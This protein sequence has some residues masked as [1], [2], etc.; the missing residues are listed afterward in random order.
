VRQPDRTDGTDHEPIWVAM[1]GSLIRGPAGEPRHFCIELFDLTERRRVAQA[2]RERAVAQAADRAK[3]ELLALVSHDVRTPLHAV[4]GFAQ[5]LRSMQLPPERQLAA[6]DHILGAGRHLLQLMNDLLD[7]TGAETGQLQLVLEPVQA[8]EVV[9]EAMEIVAGL[10]DE[11]SI[12]LRSRPAAGALAV[13]ADRHR[14]RQVLLNLLGNAIKF[15]PVGG[16]V[17]VVMGPGKILVVDNGDGIPPDQ[18]PFLFTPFHRGAAGS[19]SGVEGSGLGL[20]LSQRLMRAM[21]GDLTLVTSS[22]KGT[23]FRLTLPT[24]SPAAI[25]RELRSP[26]SMR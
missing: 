2:R 14:L 20:A 23:T 7:L 26:A 16:A 10:A 12:T 17:D 4:I 9:A 25:S 19:T 15:T 22:N 18:L 8:R 11:R 6:I 1:S 5:V 3:S 24:A 21:E 13:R